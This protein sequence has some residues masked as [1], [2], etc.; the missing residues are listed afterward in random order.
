MNNEHLNWISFVKLLNNANYIRFK[1]CLIRWGKVALNYCWVRE[2]KFDTN[3]NAGSRLGSVVIAG[4]RYLSRF[5]QKLIQSYTGLQ[6]FTVCYDLGWAISLTLPKDVFVLSKR[7]SKYINW[8]VPFC[9]L[10]FHFSLL[11][12]LV[13]HEKVH[14]K[15]VF[16]LLMKLWHSL[17]HSWIFWQAVNSVELKILR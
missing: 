17:K 15:V 2:T 12:E 11:E 4:S 9:N 3:Q 13:F 14:E 6:H 7:Q 8:I 10:L 1:Y 5:Q 16:T